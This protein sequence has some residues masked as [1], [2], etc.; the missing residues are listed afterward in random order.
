M[1]SSLAWARHAI[2]R[3][4]FG[5]CPGD[6]D[7]IAAMG[8]DAW[9][10]DQLA[11]QAI[12]LPPALA[13]RIQ[14]FATLG[15][16]PV[17]LFVEYGPPSL[18]MPGGGKPTPQARKDAARR[19]R[20]IVDEAVTARLLRAIASPRQLEESLVA[21]W[22]NHFNIFAGKGLDRLWVGAFEQEAIRPHVLGRFR[23]L[24]GATA[25]H[26]AM[27]FYLDNWLNTA[28]GSPGAR[29]RFD[30]INENYAR[31]LMELHTLG[32]AGGYTQ[33]DVIALAH[34]LTGWTIGRPQR[35]VRAG[36][37]RF[38]RRAFM[39]QPEPEN[40]GG[41]V[42]DPDR[43]DFSDKLFL[44]R[45][46]HGGGIEEGEAALDMLA[47]SPAT[48][49]RIGYKLAQYFIADQPDAAT[50]ARLAQ[51]FLASD[52]DLRAVVAA[53]F[54]SPA[55]RAPAN[56][57]AKFKSPYRYVLSAVRAAGIDVA[58]IRPLRGMLFQLGEPPYG[59]IMPQGYDDTEAAWLNPDAM[60]RRLSFAVALGRGRLRLGAA[61]A[62]GAPLD[63][64]ALM[65]TLGDA[66]SAATRAAIAAAPL[67]LRAGMVLGAPEF[68]RC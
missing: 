11:P 22:F 14:A 54:A 32:V 23:D 41:F 68:M 33:A 37:G 29:G 45:A 20:V 58:N 13:T 31:E 65:H 46:V 2:D 51:T 18:R 30:G 26:P 17:Q 43:H 49:H 44:G 55:F 25:K 9:I 56:F 50:V 60:M 52:G 6:L 21:F 67:P 42:F 59:H 39:A 27:L 28:P 3:L 8:V 24:L 12:P 16:S 35:R 61:Q 62:E 7:R 4:G 66:F 63:A 38:F 15:L 19:A 1:T 48:A 53:L 64:A 5:P 36:P 47:R 34:I 40:G 10:E 57:G